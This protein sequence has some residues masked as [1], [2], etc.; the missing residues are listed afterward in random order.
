MPTPTQRTVKGA[1]PNRFA[2]PF[3]TN[4][5]PDQRKPTAIGTRLTDHIKGTLNKVPPVKGKSVMTL[6]DIVGTAGATDIEKSHKLVFHATGDTGKSKDSAQGDVADVMAKDFNINRP[7]D[8]PAFFFHLGDVIYLHDKDARLRTEFYEPYSHYP[9]K[10]IAIPGNHDGEVFPKTDPT[11]LNAFLATFCAPSAKVPPI[12]GSI[13]RETMTQPGV[14]WR[15]VTPVADFV[16]LYSNTAENPGYISGT[17]PGPAQKKWLI[18]TLKDIAAERQAN[19]KRALVMATHHPPFSSSGHSGSAEMLADID[20]ACKAAGIMPD[21]FLCAHAHT[22]Q[23]YTRRV[24]FGGKTLAIP[25]IVCGIGG[26]NAQAI[27]PATGQTT[28][29]HT[30][31]KSHQ[32]YGYL[33]V[34]ITKT[35]ISIKGIGVTPTSQVR[36]EFDSVVVNL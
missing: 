13:F 7:A 11:S 21:V 22:Y 5:P 36:Q 30:Y 29:D 4:T 17:I 10:I 25:Y 23:R 1:D 8:S 12:A 18:T 19:G 31:E 27:A 26:F 33:L 9:G 20:D 34:E 2:H 32:G 3:F 6:A 14:Y 15:L 24:P 16:S 35:Q 28:G